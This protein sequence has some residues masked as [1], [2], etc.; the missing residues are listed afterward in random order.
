MLIL[1]RESNYPNRLA[2]F[3]VLKCVLRINMQ[4]DLE[5]GRYTN[6]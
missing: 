3:L 2:K 1:H 6:R 5:P 4:G